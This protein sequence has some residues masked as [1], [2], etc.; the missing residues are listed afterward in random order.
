MVPS[1]TSRPISLWMRFDSLT[2][3]LVSGTPSNGAR[4]PSMS[5]LSSAT[6]SSQR[7]IWLGPASGSASCSG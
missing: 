2:S 1:V 4:Q 3:A 5:C 7:S 6:E